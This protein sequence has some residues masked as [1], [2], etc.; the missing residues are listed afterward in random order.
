MAV[1]LI[2]RE[3]DACTT[4]HTHV[5]G[6]R[7]SSAEAG[8][9]S[10]TQARKRKRA[11][12]CT[13]VHEILFTHAHA[14]SHMSIDAPLGR[15]LYKGPPGGRLL[16]DDIRVDRKHIKGPPEGVYRKHIK[17]PPEGVY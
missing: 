6:G 16:K 3:A 8:P 13:I 10:D 2:D 5:R 9:Q 7:W 1:A 4:S 15:P 17:G 14:N 12:M 11:H